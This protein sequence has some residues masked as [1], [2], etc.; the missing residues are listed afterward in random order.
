MEDNFSEITAV[1]RVSRLVGTEEKV[2]FG[3]LG[4]MITG[5]LFA[6]VIFACKFV[7]VG[8]VHAIS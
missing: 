3:L 4:Y 5:L 1:R 8:I 7:V 6:L 2:G